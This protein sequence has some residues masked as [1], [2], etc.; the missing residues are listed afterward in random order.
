MAISIDW[1]NT[2]VVPVPVDAA[3]F[4][5]V[6]VAGAEGLLIERAAGSR[7]LLWSANGQM[8]VLAAP[9]GAAEMLEMAQSLQ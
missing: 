2:L 3:S 8:Y 7:Q 9:L 6:N 5:Q 4:R 1:R